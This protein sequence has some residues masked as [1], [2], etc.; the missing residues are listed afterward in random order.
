[1]G[2]GRFVPGLVCY[3]SCVE[4]LRLTEQMGGLIVW[5]EALLLLSRGEYELRFS[6]I[7]SFWSHLTGGVSG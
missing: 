4:L 2:I 5:K 6:D 1:M 7:L 3:S